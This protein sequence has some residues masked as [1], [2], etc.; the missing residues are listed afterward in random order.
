MWRVLTIWNRYEKEFLDPSGMMN[1]LSLGVGVFE[2]KRN[3]RRYLRIALHKTNR[4]LHPL[5][6]MISMKNKIEER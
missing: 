5:I 4:T 3:W 6:R 1:G 2:R